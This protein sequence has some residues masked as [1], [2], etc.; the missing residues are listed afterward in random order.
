MFINQE[1]FF[2]SIRP[3]FGGALKQSQVDGIGDILAIWQSSASKDPRH[4]A[5]ILAT[6]KW[7][8]AHTMQPVREY[9]R[10]KG[11][12]YGLPDPATGQ[13]YYGRGFVQLTWK[14]NYKKAGALLGTDLVN[15]PDRAL[16]SRMS[17]RI[18]VAGM[19]EG[20]FTGKKLSDYLNDKKTDWSGARRI[21]NKMDK[22]ATI[23]S[24][25]RQ[26]HSAI[27]AASSAERLDPAHSLP[28]PEPEAKGMA[29]S[30]TGWTQVATAATGGIIAVREATQ[31]VREAVEAAQE[32][33]GNLAVLWS[34]ACDWRVMTAL[35][36]ALVIA[37]GV[38]WWRR[39]Q[40]MV[41]R[42]A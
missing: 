10:G 37:A 20:W 12:R 25:A 16:E 40:I 21:V 31:P 15:H 9:G 5:Y 30:V 7:E 26:F 27:L 18:I 22:A 17:A 34:Y 24:I 11:R 29:R 33:K 4:L 6:A 39:R 41:E 1:T 8:T 3:L 38:T 28:P 23:A 32:A 35:S 14:D 2:T 36:A 42:G 13:T 19:V